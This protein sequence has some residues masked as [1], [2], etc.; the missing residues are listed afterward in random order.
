MEYS[1]SQL[2]SWTR[3]A[4]GDEVTLQD[5]TTT[6]DGSRTITIENEG[7]ISIVSVRA[8]GTAL[9]ASEYELEGRIITLDSDPIDGTI[10]VVQYN[11]A[12]Y[13]DAEILQFVVDAAEAVLGD[14]KMTW[15]VDTDA[16][17]VIDDGSQGFFKP[18]TTVIVPAIKQ[19][20]VQRAALAIYEAKSIN[21][22]DDAIKITNNRTS[23]DTSVG[24]GASKK[25]L[26]RIST[27]YQASLRKFLG[28][29]FIGIVR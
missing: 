1:L 21:A 5:Q 12:R 9:Q 16:Q 10:H 18:G 13:T 4:A 6:S 3:R 25:T 19:L 22:A 28:E 15:S 29:G 7:F 26:E 17:K 27:S 2:V 11:N 20:I 14:T 23:I 8:D 24:A